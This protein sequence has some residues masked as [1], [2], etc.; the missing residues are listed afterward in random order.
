MDQGRDYEPRPVVQV[1]VADAG[2][3]VLESLRAT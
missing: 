3:G 2:I 1:A